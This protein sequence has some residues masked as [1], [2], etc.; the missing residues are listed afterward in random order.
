MLSTLSH[1]I[2]GLIEFV[3]RVTAWLILA[4]VLLVAGDVLLRYLFS[5][6]SVALQELEWHLL[7]VIA[8]LGIS[9]TLK[10]GEHVR[11]DILYQFY[12]EKARHWLELLT[13][14]FIMTP[15]S[16]FI[17]Y[18]SLQ[19]VEQSYAMGEISPDPGGL[20][21]RFA[22]KAFITIGFSLLGLESIAIG[23]R[24]GLALAGKDRK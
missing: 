9:Y 20:P 17:A 22:L 23:I 10:H 7:A 14:I 3:G 5:T 4:L 19:F 21:Y 2:E 18:L 15:I 24:S 1:V 12:G 11:V 6:G 16:L 8:L 13:A